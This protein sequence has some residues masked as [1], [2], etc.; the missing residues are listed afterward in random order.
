MSQWQAVFILNGVGKG[1]IT[2]ASIREVMK[3]DRSKVALASECATEFA[4]AATC[5]ITV[6]TVEDTEELSKE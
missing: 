3:R 4:M 1:I 2:D 5:A 6:G